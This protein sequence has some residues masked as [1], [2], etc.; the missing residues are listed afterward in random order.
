MDKTSDL[1]SKLSPENDKIVRMRAAMTLGESKISSPEVIK[2][3]LD[4]LNTDESSKVRENAAR[5]LGQVGKETPNVAVALVK[6]MLDDQAESVRQI[7]AESL[8]ELGEKA[9]PALLSVLRNETNVGVIEK[10]IE[11][12]G[13]IGIWAQTEEPELVNSLVTEILS[14]IKK[15]NIE[16]LHIVAIDT[17]L[18]M[19]KATI[20]PLLRIYK[21]EESKDV[22][23]VI[24]VILEK[25]AIQLGY[26]NRAALIRIHD[27]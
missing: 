15:N 7:S 6:S 22:R 25:L 17:I 24:D 3:L 1:I 27:F 10:T 5:A 20:Y 19:S 9:V 23:T 11:T 8:G 12:L 21:S 14:V 4:V 13:R 26:R 16:S 2:A 18:K